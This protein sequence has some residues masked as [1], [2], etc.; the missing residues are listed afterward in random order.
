MNR[1]DG[2]RWEDLRE[3]ERILTGYAEA[4]T[5]D[6]AKAILLD[7][8]AEMQAAYA[9]P[10]KPAERAATRWSRRALPAAVDPDSS[11]GAATDARSASGGSGL[12][13]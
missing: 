7:L 8:V 6:E 3:A 9:A 12:V 11:D 10:R 4:E 2:M 5:R 13:R 1:F